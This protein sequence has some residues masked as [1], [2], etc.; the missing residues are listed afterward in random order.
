MGLSILYTSLSFCF[1]WDVAAHL[2]RCILDKVHSRD[3]PRETAGAAS[4]FLD[5]QDP[6][7]RDLYV[8][9]NFG[10]HQQGARLVPEQPAAQAHLDLAKS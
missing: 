2:D 9:A 8:G 10:P 6:G 5:G 7:L 1:C 4:H 3:P